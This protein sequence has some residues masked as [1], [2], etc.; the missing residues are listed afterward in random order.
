MELISIIIPTYN[1]LLLLKETVRSVLNQTYK[2]TEVLIVGDGQQ[3]DVDRFVRKIND[4]RIRYLYCEHSGLPAKVRNFGIKQSKGI[5]VAFCDD[6]DLWHKDKLTLQLELLK[7]ERKDFCF[8]RAEYIDRNSNSLNKYLYVKKHYRK[9]DRN[10][11]LISIGFICNSSVLVRKRALDTVG[12]FNEDP[13]L[14]GLEDYHLWVRILK[15]FEGCYIDQS[16]V[17]YRYQNTDSIQRKS[18][19]KWYSDQLYLLKMI[20][21][22]DY[23]D[24]IVYFIKL[25]KITIKLLIMSINRG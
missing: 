13:R 17:K 7:S 10:A 2:N 22:I 14:R 3:D 24:R 9:I 1:R 4:Q 15:H 23:I 25:C 5:F 19:L 21:R 6:D 11:L 16:L 20:D 12:L 8:S 18:I